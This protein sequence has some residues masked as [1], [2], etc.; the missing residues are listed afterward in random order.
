MRLFV[1]DSALLYFEA[2]L[3]ARLLFLVALQRDHLVRATLVAF[4]EQLVFIGKL[5][6]AEPALLVSWVVM[7]EIVGGFGL[8]SEFAPLL[9]YLLQF[10]LL[11]IVLARLTITPEIDFLQLILF[12]LDD[13]FNQPFHLLLSQKFNA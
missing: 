9:K 12:L 7:A 4:L 5:A 3:G 6:E 2:A 8:Q 1:V 11:N 10:V 13:I